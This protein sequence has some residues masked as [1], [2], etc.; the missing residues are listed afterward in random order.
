M[1]ASEALAVGNWIVKVPNVDVLSP[2]KFITAT[3]LLDLELLYI[4]APRAVIVA[5]VHDVSSKSQ[6]AV[7][8][9]VVGV[10]LV[11]LF[12]AAV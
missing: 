9:E 4:N 5:V 6:K 2:P 10:T 3:A 7:V 1:I 11:K 12:P 8:P